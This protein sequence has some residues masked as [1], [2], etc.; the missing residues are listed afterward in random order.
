MEVPTEAERAQAR[1]LRGRLPMFGVTDLLLGLAAQGGVAA[2]P[3]WS[4]LSLATTMD[5]TTAALLPWWWPPLVLAACLGAVAGQSAAPA[6]VFRQR[7]ALLALVP[8]A[9]VGAAAGLNASWLLEQFGLHLVGA[10]GW[11]G[12]AV[13]ALVWLVSLGV[14]PLVRLKRMQG[15]LPR[16]VLTALPALAIMLALEGVRDARTSRIASV[17]AMP[18]DITVAWGHRLTE[19]GLLSKADFVGPVRWSLTR[20]GRALLTETLG[21]PSRN[22]RRSWPGTRA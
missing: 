6:D 18:E 20:R 8:A 2:V 13:A 21:S 17:L 16:G 22:D 9:V 19:H 14:A 15:E 10:A 11:F 5:S 12:A 3:S 1:S 7:D 4:A